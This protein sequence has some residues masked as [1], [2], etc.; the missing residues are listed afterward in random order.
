M[1]ETTNAATGS[2][3]EESLEWELARLMSVERFDPPAGFVAHHSAAADRRAAER[4]LEAF[5][6]EKART[7][8]QGDRPFTEVLDASNAPRSTGGSPTGR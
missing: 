4:D 7:L 2:P 8:L 1:T 5:W 3:N 6:A